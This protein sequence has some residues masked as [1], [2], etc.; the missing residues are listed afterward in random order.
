MYTIQLRANGSEF[1]EVILW[2]PMGTVWP[3]PN[4]GRS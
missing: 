4:S 2:P 3:V 1:D